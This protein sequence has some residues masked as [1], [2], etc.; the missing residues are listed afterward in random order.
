MAVSTRRVVVMVT[1]PPHTWDRGLARLLS[2]RTT[3]PRVTPSRGRGQPRVDGSGQGG[4][5]LDPLL[6]WAAQPWAWLPSAGVIPAT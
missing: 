1:N 2:T 5:E 3:G 4:T 6:W